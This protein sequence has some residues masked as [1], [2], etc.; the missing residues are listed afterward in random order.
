MLFIASD[1]AGFQL[2]KF[3]LKYLKTQLKLEA[4][5]LGPAS[6]QEG[7]DF[8]DFAVPLTKKVVADKNNRGIL[9]CG[10]GHGMC[11]AANKIKG[12]RAIIGYSI[13]GAEMGRRHNDANILCLAGR[14]I[15]EEHAAAIT[16][17]FLATEFQNEERLIRR[18]GKI[19]ELEK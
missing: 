18:N 4:E 5:D 6:F 14:V 12:A 16:K 15:S 8:P 3:L 7:D 19:A 1:H 13:E 2:K 9:I 10:S 17:K 11:I